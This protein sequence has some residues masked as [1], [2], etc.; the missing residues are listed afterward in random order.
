[1]TEEFW[2]KIFNSTDFETAIEKR[3]KVAHGA[4]LEELRLETEPS[5]ED[6]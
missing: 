1:M 2:T 6:E 3:Y 5:I 4:M